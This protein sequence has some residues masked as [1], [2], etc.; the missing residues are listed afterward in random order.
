MV[1]ACFQHVMEGEEKTQTVLGIKE[2]LTAHVSQMCSH[3][4]ITLEDPF[5]PSA[6][7]LGQ[8]SHSKVT[9]L[10]L[11]RDWLLQVGAERAC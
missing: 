4:I 10:V 7:L 9:Q 8:A 1:L 11:L 3:L 5:R 2:H 6:P